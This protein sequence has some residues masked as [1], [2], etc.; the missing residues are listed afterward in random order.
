[1][2]GMDRYDRMVERLAGAARRARPEDA[3]PMPGW[4]ATRVLAR[5]RERPEGA[6]WWEGLAARLAAAACVLALVAVLL[7]GPTSNGAD[8]VTGLTSALLASELNP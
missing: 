6:I 3:G 7:P 2:N 4:L 5:L 1:M 8:D